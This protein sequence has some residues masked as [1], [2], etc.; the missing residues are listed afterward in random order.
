MT[1]D[2]I[3]CKRHRTHRKVKD[4]ANEV[5]IKKKRGTLFSVARRLDR[6]RTV[7]AC[8]LCLLPGIL[9]FSVL[10]ATKSSWIL[11]NTT[12]KI[13]EHETS[14][15]RIVLIS[16]I[17]IYIRVVGLLVLLPSFFSLLCDIRNTL[18]RL[19]DT[20]TTTP[21]VRLWT[22]P[23][24]FIR[25]FTINNLVTYLPAPYYLPAFLND[26]PRRAVAVGQSSAIKIK[27]GVS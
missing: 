7:V 10:E 17:Y 12:T 4:Q 13:Q 21:C 18:L 19:A 6:C 2:L 25:G 9:T 16:R 23:E 26:H 8:S 20:N 11:W 27:A 1:L 3:R 24:P 15:A 5:H 14:R 22:T